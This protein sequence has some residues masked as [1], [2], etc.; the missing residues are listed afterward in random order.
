MYSSNAHI[1]A[2]A[3]QMVL[4][5]YLPN[6]ISLDILEKEYDIDVHFNDDSVVY[7]ESFGGI[8]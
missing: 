4:K 5:S 3:L 7:F 1:H 8:I 2:K 6:L